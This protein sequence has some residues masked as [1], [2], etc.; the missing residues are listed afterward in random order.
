MV[1]GGELGRR[2]MERELKIEKDQ[3]S[4]WVGDLE[5]AQRKRGCG[6]NDCGPRYK[7][8]T[9]VLISPQKNLKGPR[10]DCPYS[11]C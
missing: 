5:R 4:D 8:V 1:L 3:V 6:E 2:G 9:G 11:C 7:K 10:T